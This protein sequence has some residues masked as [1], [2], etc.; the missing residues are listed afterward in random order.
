MKKTTFKTYATSVHCATVRVL[1]YDF[2][3]IFYVKVSSLSS[4]K[5]KGLELEIKSENVVC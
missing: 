5:R 1:A 4:S 3:L 2:L